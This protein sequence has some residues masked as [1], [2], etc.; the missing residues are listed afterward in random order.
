MSKIN[1]K[2][3]ADFIQKPI[4]IIAF[5][6]LLLGIATYSNCQINKDESI[7]Y[8]YDRGY[9]K[10]DI[11]AYTMF[12]IPFTADSGS[13]GEVHIKGNIINIFGKIYLNK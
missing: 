8:L 2:L 7:T 3:V 1:I 9:S 4:S 11:K 12:Y 10:I 5:M 6:M 13:R